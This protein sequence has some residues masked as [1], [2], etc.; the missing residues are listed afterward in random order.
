[1]GELKPASWYDDYFATTPEA[2]LSWR[3]TTW[4]PLYEWALSKIVPSDF[5]LGIGCGCG[6]FAQALKDIRVTRYHGYDFSHVAIEE[7]RRRC[8]EY[9]F[10]CADILTC[11]LPVCYTVAVALEVLEHTEGDVIGRLEKGVRFV[12]SVP[13]FDAASHVRFFTDEDSVRQAFEPRLT[14]LKI[15]RIESWWGFTGVTR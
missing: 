6:P 9:L 5:V 3:E 7:A 15:K 1:M 2:K 14:E 4:R 10:T 8:P 13:T 11:S 12:G